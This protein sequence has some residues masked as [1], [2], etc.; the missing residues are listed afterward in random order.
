MDFRKFSFK[1]NADWMLIL[2]LL[3][4][5]LGILLSLLVMIL[6]EFDLIHLSR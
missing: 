3:P 2:S 1:N 4:L 6:S 5:V